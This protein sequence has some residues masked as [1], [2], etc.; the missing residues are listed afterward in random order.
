MNNNELKHYGVLGMRWG[1]RKTPE[2]LARRVTRMDKANEKFEKKLNA[3][4]EA[5]KQQQLAKG[6][7]KLAKAARFERKA[8]K[9]ERKSKPSL[10]RSENKAAKNMVKANKYRAKANKYRAKGE[11]L[12]SKASSYISNQSAYK[13]KIENN[14]RLMDTMNKTI[15]AINDGTIRQGKIFMHYE[16]SVGNPSFH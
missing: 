5:S 1:F 3:N 6:Q 7:R 9:F 13:T 8:L 14:K 2:Q 16:G 15:S 4:K 10:F 12:S 11:L